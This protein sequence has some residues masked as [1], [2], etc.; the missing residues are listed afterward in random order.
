VSYDPLKR[1]KTGPEGKAGGLREQDL[2]MLSDLRALHL[3]CVCREYKFDDDGRWKF[4][5]AIPRAR[6]A[7]EIEGGVWVSGRHTRGSGFVADCVKYNHAT[8]LG[9]TVFRFPTQAILLG[10]ARE[11]LALWKKNTLDNQVKTVQ[12]SRD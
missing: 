4:D 6:L 11:I 8:A 10:E 12:D 7:C 1:M 2:I 9:W 5:F 3:G